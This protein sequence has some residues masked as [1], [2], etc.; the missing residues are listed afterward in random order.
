MRTMNRL[1]LSVGMGMLLALTGACSSGGSSNDKT[2]LDA[3]TTMVGTG[4][5]PAAAMDAGVDGPAVCVPSG[6]EI[7]DGRD[8][9]CSG[10]VDD[11]L[12]CV[13]WA[14]RA[15]DGDLSVSGMSV[16]GGSASKAPGF[17]LMAVSGNTL[18]V[19]AA[20]TG[21]APG[22]ELLVINLRG[23]GADS[24]SVGNWE[25]VFV[26]ATPGGQV[27]QLESPLR[28]T[29][30]V[31]NSNTDLAG[32]VVLVQ[33]VPHFK[34]VSVSKDGRLS[35]APGGPDAL[36]GVLFFRATSV[37]VAADGVLNADSAGYHGAPGSGIGRSGASGES[38]TGPVGAVPSPDAN[39]GGGG[40][41]KSNCDMDGCQGQSKGAG[42]GG[43]SFAADG[44]KGVNNGG[45]H[46]A[47]LPGKTYGDA[48]LAKLFFG[49][50]GGGGAGGSRGPTTR[51]PGGNGGGIVA[52]FA[53]S[54]D[55]KGLISSRG[56]KGSTDQN[57]GMSDGTGGGGGG[58]GGTVWISATKVELVIEALIVMGGTGA[59]NGGG[60]GGFGRV[61]IDYKMAGAFPY[62]SDDAKDMI[63]N[64]S[65]IPPVGHTSM[66][67]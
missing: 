20:P 29:Y 49:S 56:G 10:A 27:I 26:K 64:A 6:A 63:T 35:A 38:L 39:F 11:G 34:S 48:M 28:K 36:G 16:L 67:Q 59:C 61:R 62:D 2:K 50:G 54:I 58:A 1:G 19:A 21:L 12:N 7:C 53:D 66:L 13:N 33:R 3:D 23:T 4:G 14:G 25:T 30:G 15:T 5:T 42:G 43:A 17:K 65:I 18:T 41:G 9:D 32:Q 51:D 37:T 52:I 40:G 55:V 45:L 47:G 57:C 60:D 44:I 31:G 8:N 22:D 24:A 46:K